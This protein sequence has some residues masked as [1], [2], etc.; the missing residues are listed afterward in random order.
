M[1]FA[2][3]VRIVGSTP[4][5][6]PGERGSDFIGR[7][8]AAAQGADRAGWD[9]AL[10]YTSN[11]ALDPWLLAQILI[12]STRRVRPLVAV[13]PIYEHP[14]TVA[15]QASTLSALYDRGVDF[16]FVA[17]DH[18]RD[19][20]A[21]NDTVP[22]D[23]RYA[24][25]GEYGLIVKNLLAS[26]RPVSF[27]GSYYSVRHLQL[28]QRPGTE[29]RPGFFMSGSSAAA[30]E[31]ASRIG[32]CAIQYPEEP[33]KVLPC[34]HGSLQLGLR[35]GVIARAS[36]GE[37]WDVAHRRFPPDDEGEAIRKFAARASD[38][39]WVRTLLDA[40]EQAPA[41]TYWLSPFRR[42]QRA[43]PYLVGSE[44]EVRT[45]LKAYVEAGY[46]TFLID[47]VESDEEACSITE[48]IRAA[49]A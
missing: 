39:E 42:F 3:G 20:E 43:C 29:M 18:P 30:R 36:T 6:S 25:L 37:A 2:R 9:A 22:H 17:G 11:N 1:T 26:P 49:A 8:K 40:A 27:S 34:Q 38:S 45:A 35:L 28:G 47:A 13:Q 41:G 12:Q 32:A 4:T 23:Q 15:N 44:A 21:L 14:F 5:R 31:T 46:R 48:L 16:N 33:G 24:R 10:I 19:R 7:F